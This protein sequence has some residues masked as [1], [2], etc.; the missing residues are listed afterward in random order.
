MNKREIVLSLLDSN[1][2]T[3]YIPA[4]FFLHFNKRFHRGQPAIDKHIEFF[5]YTG[6]DIVKIQYE[7]A[8]PPQPDIQQPKDWSNIPFIREDFYQDQWQIAKGLVEMAGKEALV[9]MTLYSPFMLAG[10]FTGRELLEKNLRSDPESVKKGLEI[11]TDSLLIFVRG[12]IKNGVDGFYHS[13]QGGEISR[14]GGSPIFDNYIK[15]FDL[16]VMEEINNTSKFNI[17]HICDYHDGY[18]DLSPFFDYPGD[19]VNCSLRLSTLQL[20][21]KEVSRMFN[22]P[23]MGGL[24]RKGTIVHG[25]PS[26]IER[27]IDKVVKDAPEDFLLAADCTLP[28]DINW[29]KIKNTISYT[30]KVKGS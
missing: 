11:I 21:G 19:I 24:N 5:N 26:E 16:T 27:E 13:T 23:F 7:L 30:H 12:C 14:F 6:M 10:Q 2:S 20:T 17:L 8:M 18:K 3:P 1:T 29:D 22:R 15:P 9:I 25:T 4:G 28:S